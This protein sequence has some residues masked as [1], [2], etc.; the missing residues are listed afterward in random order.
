MINRA[1]PIVTAAVLL[2]ACASK[3]PDAELANARSAIVEA[4]SANADAVAPN[5]LTSAQNKL[6]KAQIL[7]NDGEED[8]ARRLAQ[9]SRADANA[10][11]AAATE[12]R[13]ESAE[14]QLDVTV[15]EKSA[16]EAQLAAM[17][18]QQTTRGYEVTLGDVLFETDSATLTLAGRDRVTRIANYLR[19]YPGEAVIIEGHADATG[20]AAYN[21]RLSR[22]RAEAVASS[23][24]GLGIATP[25]IV[26]TGLGESSPIAS[27][28]TSVGRQLNRRVDVIFV[29]RG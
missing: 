1:I 10:A 3:Q 16:L 4:Q 25:R 29:D 14:A 15:A 18:A 20:D 23:L 7:A 26:Y 6:A 13:A 5:R 17:Q 11:L 12:A 19:A 24:L 9:E 27:N 22:Q 21:R 2:A 28:A 8:K